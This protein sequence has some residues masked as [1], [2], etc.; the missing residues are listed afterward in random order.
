VTAFK[1]VPHGGIFVTGS[2]LAP[3]ATLAEPDV[4]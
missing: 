3:N 1:D 4:G 2:L